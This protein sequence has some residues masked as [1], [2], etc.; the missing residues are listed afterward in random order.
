MVTVK[1][2]QEMINKIE[3]FETL[4]TEAQVVE[5][6]QTNYSDGEIN[7][8]DGI[9]IDYPDWRFNVRASK[10]EPIIRLNIS[11]SNFKK[12]RENLEKIKTV[13]GGKIH[14]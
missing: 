7:T 13:I 11:G 5:E 4:K 3:Q 1:E 14:A 8:I 6:L 2:F 12:V 10:S 9:T